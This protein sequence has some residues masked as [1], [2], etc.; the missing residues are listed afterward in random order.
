M[1]THILAAILANAQT[2]AAGP[3][4]AEAKIDLAVPDYLK[5][6]GQHGT[7]V[8]EGDITP[9]AHVANLVIAR[10]SRSDELDRLALE[11]LTKAR[12]GPDLMETNPAKGRFQVRFYQT[13]GL[14]LGET[15]TCLQA[16]LDADWYGKAFPNERVE[17]S[18]LYLLIQSG[19][20]V[21]GMKELSFAKD[22]VRFD[23]VWLA[24]LEACRSTPQAGFTKTLIRLGKK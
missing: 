1:V 14:D 17:R 18:P 24:A 5:P 6:T 22:P 9:D 12:M 20:T 19:G 2:Q 23:Q 7:V 15:Y 3:I 8:I 21:L 16:V 10:S 11:R 4:W 13:Q